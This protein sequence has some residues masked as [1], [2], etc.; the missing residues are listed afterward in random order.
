[1]SSNGNKKY[2]KYFVLALALSPTLVVFQNCSRLKSPEEVALPISADTDFEGE[3]FASQGISPAV[4]A[5][6][7]IYNIRSRCYL[8]QTLENAGETEIKL[9]VLSKSSPLLKQQVLVKRIATNQY[10]LQFQN[11]QKFSFD[12][13]SGSNAVGTLIQPYGYWGGQNQIF[14]LVRQNDGSYQ[15]Q[16]FAGLNIQAVTGKVS[17]ELTTN[18][19]H[20]KFVLTEVVANAVPTPTVP[21]VSYVN[22]YNIIEAESYSTQQGFIQV[23][24]ALGYSDPGDYAVYNNLDFGSDGAKSLNMTVGVPSSGAGSAYEIR[25]GSLNGE[26]ISNFV[27]QLTGNW[28]IFKS[29][30]LNLSRTVTGVQSIYVI[31]RGSGFSD[32]DKFQ[33]SKAAVA[34][35]QPP[36]NPTPTPNPP[37]QGLTINSVQEIINDMQMASE[38][39]ISTAYSSMR[40]SGLGSWPVVQAPSPQIFTNTNYLSGFDFERQQQMRNFGG[41]IDSLIPIVQLWAAK[42][43]YPSSNTII[44]FRNF[45]VQYYMNGRWNLQGV[46]GVSGSC[47]YEATSFVCSST[48][49]SDQFSSFSN[50]V[51]KVEPPIAGTGPEARGYEFWIRNADGTPGFEIKIPNFT[52]IQGF[53]VTVEV[54]LGLKNPN[55]PDDR[56]EFKYLAAANFDM[57]STVSD[58]CPLY[59]RY[60]NTVIPCNFVDAVAGR[61]KYIKKEWRSFNAASLQPTGTTYTDWY[62][63]D[64]NNSRVNPSQYEPYV[65]TPAFLRSSQPYLQ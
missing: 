61:L 19:C 43:G 1:M 62:T 57:Q 54:R 14:K 11:D 7:K 48:R 40:Q 24:G 46:Y 25:L 5:D 59:G 63:G 34:V 10:Q 17:Q 4:I 60:Y 15:I 35:Q 21:A 45:Q 47:L 26:L 16:T 50:N 30:S 56:D 31:S 53:I 42:E 58:N 2:L 8:N 13:Q 49:T 20:Q 32:L 65:L 39:K 6:N 28:D 33:F 22:P 27:V 37:N 52:S 41:R 29:Q 3:S 12:V 55:G 51:F 23:G 18:R 38:S 44:E 64:W 9:A 36:A